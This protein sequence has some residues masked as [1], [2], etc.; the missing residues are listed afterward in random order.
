MPGSCTPLDGPL[1]IVALTVAAPT[2]QKIATTALVK[3]IFV[4]P[5]AQKFQGDKKNGKTG[6]L[7]QRRREN[8][9]VIGFADGLRVLMPK[10]LIILCVSASLRS[11]F[12]YRKF[13]N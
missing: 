10:A 5:P 8:Q 4:G 6:L 3:A 12:A 7:T 13:L 11:N 2:A 1:P 9:T